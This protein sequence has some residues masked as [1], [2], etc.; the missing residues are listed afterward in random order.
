[1][2]MRTLWIGK[3]SPL[4][5]HGN[6]LHRQKGPYTWAWAHFVLPKRLMH[7]GMKTL[8]TGKKA[9]CMGMGTLCSG[10]M[11]LIY[12]HADTLH[13]QKGPY[14]WALKQSSM[15]KRPLHIGMGTLCTGKKTHVYGHGDTLD[16]QQ[17]Y[18]L[19]ILNAPRFGHA[20]TLQ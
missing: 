17:G 6:I 14:T 3:K 8:Y 2:G 13:W 12:G 10:K 1:M 18:I 4:Y 11:P 9:L 5:G 15:A 20:T 16:W 7:L 19:N